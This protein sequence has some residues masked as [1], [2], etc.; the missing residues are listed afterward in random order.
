MSSAACWWRA[1]GV[2]GSGLGAERS[3][4]EENGVEM[5]ACCMAEEREGRRRR[6]RRR[7][8]LLAGFGGFREAWGGE[9][10]CQ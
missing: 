7:I 10:G 6:R 5:W 4:G 2:I 1:G 9:C 8:S 3:W